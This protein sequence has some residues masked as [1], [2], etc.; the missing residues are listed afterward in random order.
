MKFESKYKM[1]HSRNAPENIVCEI[2]AILSTMK[3]TKTNN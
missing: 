2:A 1:F 3:Q